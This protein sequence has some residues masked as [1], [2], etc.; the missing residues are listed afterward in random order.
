MPKLKD[1]LEEHFIAGGVVSTPALGV[2][3][4]FKTNMKDKPIVEVE[5]EE[6]EEPIDEKKFMESV[7]NFNNIG[8]ELYRKTSLKELAELIIELTDCKYQ[9]KFEER[10]QSTFVRNRI[11]CPKKAENEI[12][13]KSKIKLKEGLKELIKWRSQEM[14]EVE[15]RRKANK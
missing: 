8:E 14:S 4:T 3:Q 12:N 1:L 2:G 15:A 5:D 9:I 10:S 7:N 6:K 11:G 13:F